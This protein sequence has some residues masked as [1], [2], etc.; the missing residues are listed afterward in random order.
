MTRE[1]AV[2]R[3]ADITETVFWAEAH[4]ADH[5]RITLDLAKTQANADKEAVMRAYCRAIAVEI[6]SK[7]SDEELAKM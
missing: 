3:W 4:I 2:D 6:T 1:E 7:T 5:W